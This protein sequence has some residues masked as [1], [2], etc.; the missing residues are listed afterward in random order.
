[1]KRKT[2]AQWRT[3]F[4]AAGL[5]LTRQ[6]LLICRELEGRYDHPDVE[7]LYRA[8]KPRL[9]QISVFTVYRTMNAL[10]NAGLAWRVATWRGHARYDAN[11][12]THGHFLCEKCGRIDDLAAGAIGAGVCAFAAAKGEVHR[13]EVMLTGACDDC[14]AAARALPQ[15]A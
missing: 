2:S 5:R 4:N 13:V 11:V 15:E 1:M 7:R 3:A 12:E 6:R 14:L 9:K 10:E 8:V